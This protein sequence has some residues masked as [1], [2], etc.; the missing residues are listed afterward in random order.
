MAAVAEAQ[1]LDAGRPL[2][3]PQRIVADQVRQRRGDLSAM[4]VRQPGVVLQIQPP[5]IGAFREGELGLLAQVRPLLLQQLAFQLLAQFGAR[6]R[7]A[8]AP[9][10]VAGRQGGQRLPAH[11][12]Q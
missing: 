1:L 10:R 3:Q 11:R 2:A 7:Q 9:L 5:V 12:A 6:R 8:G 4:L